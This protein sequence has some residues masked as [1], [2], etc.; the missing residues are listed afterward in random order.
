[1]KHWTILAILVPVLIG[2]ETPPQEPSVPTGIAVTALDRGRL[3]GARAYF[4]VHAPV[5]V[6]LDVI[7][8]FDRFAEF[9]PGVLESKSVAASQEGGQAFVRLSRAYRD[10]INATCDYTITEQETGFKVEY[11]MTDPSHSLWAQHGV[12]TLL[13]AKGGEWT[14]IDQEILISAMS[15]NRQGILD[16]ARADAE[17]IQQ[18]IEEVAGVR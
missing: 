2:C 18:R 12:F 15:S 1:M 7:I 8:D 14:V 11:V 9:R 16:A 17:A 13:S 5:S 4:A 6:A 10:E 3:A